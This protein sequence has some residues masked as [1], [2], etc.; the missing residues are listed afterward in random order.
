MT[1]IKRFFSRYRFV[2]QP[3]PALLKC[4]IL[5]TLVVSIVS[6][7]ALGA[8]TGG[9]Q[10]QTDDLRHQAAALEQSNRELQEKNDRLGT[11]ES[12]KEI[13]REELGMVEKNDTVIKVK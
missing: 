12:V 1:A 2:Y 9:T 3:S 6:L 4:A 8:I 11:V 10:S 7:S 13:A 5:A